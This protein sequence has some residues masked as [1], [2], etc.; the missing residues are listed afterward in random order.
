M[1]DR[2]ANVQLWPGTLNG[3]PI[4]DGDNINDRL[5]TVM[6]NPVANA[7]VSGMT[8]QYDIRNLIGRAG[9]LYPDKELIELES[10][11]FSGRNSWDDAM[12]LY[13]LMKHYLEGG[14]SS[15]FAW[16]MVLNET[17]ISTWHWRQN[18]L[19]TIN[20]NTGKV[21]YNGEYYVMRH[22]SQFVKPGA[23][24]VLATGH[25]GDKLASVN[26]D[27]STVLVVANLAKR[28]YEVVLKVAG[29]P[30]GTFKA[31]LPGRS[32]NTFILPAE[33]VFEQHLASDLD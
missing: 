24:R 14:A 9:K 6:E 12:D 27:G 32:V 2:N 5:V 18:S 20:Q 23:K 22:F 16:N 30:A 10:K 3:D 17:G 8:F 4:N 7:F 25:W 26:P 21:T 19:I 15:Y 28:S 11:C 29:R 13:G 1:H 33:C 31:E